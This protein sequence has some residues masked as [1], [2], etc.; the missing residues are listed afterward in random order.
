[1][2]RW[3][4]QARA[5]WSSASASSDPSTDAI[6]RI[7]ADKAIPARSLVICRGAR[8]RRRVLVPIYLGLCQAEGLDSGNAAASMLISANLGMAVPVSVVHSGGGRIIRVAGLSLSGA[9]V[10]VAELVQY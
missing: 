6:E 9:E 2:I 3:T 1:M 8:A 10:R 5:F 7:G 4:C